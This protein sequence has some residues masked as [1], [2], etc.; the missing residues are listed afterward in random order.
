MNPPI[1]TDTGLAGQDEQL[2]CYGHP[3]TP[4]KLRCS[5]CERPICGRCAI[6]AS[7][8]QH[9]PECVAEARRR[10]PK[11]R[12]QLAATAPAV[13]T[14][15]V[16]NVV[17]YIGQILIPGGPFTPGLTDRLVLDPTAVTNGEWYRLLTA[18]VLHGGIIHIGFNSYVLFV[19]GPNVERAFGSARFV[20]MYVVAGL[21]GS[22]LSFAVPPAQRSLGASGAI[23]GIVG[24]L[25]VYL[26]NR[27]KSQ[28]VRDSMRSLLTFIGINLAIGFILPYIDNFGHIGGLLGG[29][30]LGLGFDRPEAENE[31][32][33]PV[34][35]VLTIL[36]VAG[37]ALGLVLWR[38]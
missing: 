16:I 5:R 30:L 28:F 14:I 36:L 34:V 2:Y 26:Y 24:V 38:S 8:G 22:A 37:A 15:L 21:M 10:A 6:P 35:Q 18:M 29:I 3:K 20:A 27:R 31:M 25:L 32:S 33:R 19:F 12:T 4:T 1:E 9:C 13:M 23:F 17:M 7:V 11:V